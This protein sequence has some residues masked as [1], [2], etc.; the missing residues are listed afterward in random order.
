[1]E[2]HLYSESGVCHKNADFMNWKSNIVMVHVIVHES[3]VE[4]Q[5]CSGV[6]NGGWELLYMY[7]CKHKGVWQCSFEVEVEL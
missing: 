7:N 3:F 4:V 2:C 1:M 6:L 5:F